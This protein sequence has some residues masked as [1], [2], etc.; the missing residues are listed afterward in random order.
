MGHP[1]NRTVIPIRNVYK[2]EKA[3]VIT[4]EEKNFKALASLCM[5]DA[6]AQLLASKQKGRRKLQ[7]KCPWRSEE[8]TAS[9]EPE[10]CTAGG[11]PQC[12]C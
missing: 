4:G 9:L 11:E 3:R 2:K 8:G 6:N 12:G 7:S 5:A 10:L 1:A